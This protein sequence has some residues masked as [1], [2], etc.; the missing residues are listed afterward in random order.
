MLL[1]VFW[2]LFHVTVVLVA[3]VV[4]AVKD[5]LFRLWS[6]FS[7]ADNSLPKTNDEDILH[8]FFFSYSVV[9]FF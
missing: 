1:L 8:C 6:K 9:Q 3:R 4:V 7:V 2:L 5:T